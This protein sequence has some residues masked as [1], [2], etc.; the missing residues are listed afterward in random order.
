MKPI[1]TYS[2]IVLIFSLSACANHSKRKPDLEERFITEI[3]QSNLKLFTYSV[4][5]KASGKQRPNRSS[6]EAR[7]G[8][9]RMPDRSRMQDR[10]R[11][12]M[13][14]GLLV[15]LEQTG[16]CR[17]GYIE[18]NSSIGRGESFIRGECQE[19]ATDEDRAKFSYNSQ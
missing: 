18:L 2:L 16:Y 10:M 7:K 9:G 6:K 8:E 15:K 5:I 11:K 19:G 14:E 4:S 3:T 1:L 17:E 12:K 13:E